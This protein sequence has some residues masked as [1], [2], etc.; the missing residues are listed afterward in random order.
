MEFDDV[1]KTTFAARSFTDDPVPDERLSEILDIARFAPSGGNRQGVRVIVVRDPGT[2]AQL[3]ELSK[4]AARRYLA[5]RFAGENPWN[6]VHPSAVTA[7]DLAETP[8]V[9]EFVAPIAAAPVVLVVAVD[10]AVVAATDSELDRVGVVSGASVYPLVWN[11]LTTARSRGY[12]GT[13][14]TMVSA[15]EPAVRELLGIPETFAVA[16]A[17]PIGR[18]VKQLTRLRRRPVSDFVTLERFD[19]TALAG[20]ADR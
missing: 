4:P 7:T 11:I 14:T 10:L 19:G 15:Q 3:A 12:G 18:P 16:A 1:V 17:V 2:K 20:P 5:Q 8:G 6:P 9:D 13:I